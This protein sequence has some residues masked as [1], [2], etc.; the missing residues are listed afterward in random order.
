M[1]QMSAMKI[2]DLRVG[3]REITVELK[4]THNKPEAVAVDG[5]S[6]TGLVPGE[7]EVHDMT[8]LGI[9]VPGRVYLGAGHF[10]REAMQQ[11]REQVE[12]YFNEDDSR[13][14]EAL[15]LV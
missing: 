15:D 4:Y 14:Y 2:V 11:A 10:G 3:G 9:G 13:V 8:V 6:V 7:V 12:D 1:K 5:N